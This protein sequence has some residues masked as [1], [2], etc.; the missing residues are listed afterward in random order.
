MNSISR[1][2]KFIYGY[3]KRDRDTM[4]FKTKRGGGG[5]WCMLK[6]CCPFSYTETLYGNG[7]DTYSSCHIAVLLRFTQS[8]KILFFA[9]ILIGAFELIRNRHS[10]W[11]CWSSFVGTQRLVT[12]YILVWKI[13][14]FNAVHTVENVYYL[15]QANRSDKQ[16]Y[17][18]IEIKLIQYFN[19]SITL[20]LYHI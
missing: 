11:S 17:K 19:V 9:S 6:K 16:Q 15:L 12:F 14:E 8:S 13:N 3:W 10:F 2:W 20:S 18:K 4:T 1:V 7:Q 5:E